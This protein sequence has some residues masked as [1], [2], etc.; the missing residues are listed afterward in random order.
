MRFKLS[1]AIPLAILLMHTF[2]TAVFAH[3][4]EIEAVSTCMAT[5]D[6]R[7]DYV[8]S[9]W[10][11]AGSAGLHNNVTV[12]YILDNGQTFNLP[13]G[14]FTDANQRQFSGSFVVEG[15]VAGGWIKADPVGAW[16]SGANY[17]GSDPDGDARSA[18]FIGATDCKIDD[19]GDA[20]ASYG[21]AYHEIV[22]FMTIG[23]I[24]D[25]EGGSQY[26]PGAD[27]DDLNA[28]D[29]ESDD[30]DGVVFVNGIGAPGSTNNQLQ[31]SVFNNKLTR[32]NHT[33][34]D[35]FSE[36]S[37]SKNNGTNNW[38]GNWTESED[39]DASASGGRIRIANGQLYLNDS[40]DTGRTPE[41]QR[42]ADLSNSWSAT[43]TFDYS[44]PNT[45]EVDDR[46][47]V[48]VWTPYTGWQP[49]WTFSG[50]ENGQFD[51][52]ISNFI[53]NNTC[54]KFEVIQSYGGSD[55]YFA[56]DNIQIKYSQLDNT[57]AKV[58]LS[59]WIDF[60]GNGV[61]DSAEKVISDLEINNNAQLQNFTLLYNVPGD[62]VSG[63]TYA[64]FRLSCERG[65]LPIGA[66]GADVGE[67]EDYVITIP[68]VPTP[69][70]TN[71]PVPPTSTPTNTSVPPTSTPTSTPV[72]PTA[73]PTNT[74]S[75]STS[76]TTPPPTATPTNTASPLA[77][78]GDRVWKDLN[79]NG[80]QDADEHG[81]PGVQVKLWTDDDNNGTP[82]TQIAAAVTDHNGLYLFANLEPSKIY[83]VQ[84]VAPDDCDVTTP[85]QGGNEADSDMDPISGL[86]PPVKLA[87]G[88]HNSTID[89]GLTPTR[90]IASIGDYA[91]LDVN[92]DGKQDS[93]EAGIQ[94]VTVTLYDGA[95]AVVGTRQTDA[96]GN[97]LFADLTPG[98]YSLCFAMPAG[99][100]TIS[101]PDN[102][103]SDL[104]DSDVDPSTG[105]TVVTELVAGENDLSWDA[106]MF[107]APNLV[108]DKVPNT[109]L[110]QPG[111][112]IVYAISY[113]NEG[114]ADA[115][116]VVIH[117][118]VPANTTFLPENSSAGW[119]CEN[120]AVT[121][122]TKCAYAIGD[123][124]AGNASTGQLSFVVMINSFLSP[125]VTSID[126]VILIA[127]GDGIQGQSPKE[128]KVPLSKPTSIDE[129]GEP[130]NKRIFMPL[131]QT[132]SGFKTQP[133]PVPTLD[134]RLL[135]WGCALVDSLTA[136][137]PALTNFSM[138]RQFNQFCAE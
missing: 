4:A 114:G 55:E 130:L 32:V 34:G 18:R 59:G 118:T 54:I 110:A 66:P 46:V 38:L 44:T 115:A 137:Q 74:P 5:G 27:G 95:G 92:K 98:N 30:E 22:P 65:T 45:L 85:N 62:A 35:K 11:G 83:I 60:N 123:L 107:G 81:I 99:H 24:V 64:R 101:P 56:V 84:F 48:S 113:S 90:V 72:P 91:W 102:T 126:N 116:D 78:L 51:V 42:C 3:H 112:V 68:N 10:T 75:V 2:A 49:L 14:A 6:Y 77:S 122:G 86:T 69:T 79:Q 127:G 15:T 63:Q 41:I 73:T 128:V 120:G 94:G 20:P 125:E 28:H 108:V 21:D 124:A 103:S 39:P 67:V 89:A 131:I 16:G 25:A 17:D 7:V 97:Y 40:P 26:S 109:Q 121:A 96:K 76:T 93:H 119:V 82:D 100:Y 104:D 70:P 31:V 71:T 87:P 106:G 19:F 47:A 57:G 53:S 88:E 129:G 61:F 36:V 8:V 133:N 50:R 135:G 136:S 117:E 58:Y 37:Y 43:L 111:S 138:V 132:R 80:V 33:V 23:Q 9:S 52:D 134:Q 13:T 12:K 1:I 105:C 29:G